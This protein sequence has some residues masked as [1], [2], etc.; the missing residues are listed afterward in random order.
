M[1]ARIAFLL[2]FIVVQTG[3]SQRRMR[4]QELPREP[5]HDN[6]DL[7][8]A[9]SGFADSLAKEDAFSGVVLIAQH[10]N[11]VFHNAYGY[12]D[13]E[14]KIP[15]KPDTKFNIGS[16]NKS[17]TALAI[18]QL[19]DEGKISLDDKLKKFLPE[20]PNR[21]AA[22]KVTIQHL[23]DMTSG[24]GDIFCPAY[25]STPKE[26]LRSIEDFIPLFAGEPLQFEPGTQRQY[27]NGGY[28]LLG[29]IIQK[30]SGLDYYTYVRE[31]I[32][33]PAGMT[34]T[35]YYA[36][37]A[38]VE[39]LARGYMRADTE[40]KDNYPTL[41][42]RG[43]SAGGG[44]STAE[45]LL[46]YTIAL[47][48]GKIKSG[49]ADVLGIGDGAPGLNAALEWDPESGYA[50][51]VLANLDPPAAGSVARKIRSWLPNV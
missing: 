39:N 26:K 34:V 22:E 36:K 44:Y 49:R 43:S 29:A 8:Y 42:G 23:L 14:E 5:K 38:A 32:F 11:I 31:K 37:N 12:A 28:I 50:I 48:Q 15:N 51:I 40:L 10:G 20:Y 35:E 3:F 30:V 6:Q 1:R 47:K 7:A 9:V 4:E 17:F 18:R 27:S 45:D 19:V 25:E 16:L 21:E 13:R 46:K 2:L 24:I 41:P 33:K